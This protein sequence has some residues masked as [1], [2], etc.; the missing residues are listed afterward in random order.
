[1]ST[2]SF[3][4]IRQPFTRTGAPKPGSDGAK[5]CRGHLRGLAAILG[6][7]LGLLA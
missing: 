3:R 4:S 5:P 2:V 1:M 6:P 7:V